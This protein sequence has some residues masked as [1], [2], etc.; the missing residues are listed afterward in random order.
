MQLNSLLCNNVGVTVSLRR[1]MILCTRVFESA[2]PLAEAQ[3]FCN[4]GVMAATTHF[5]LLWPEV[6]VEAGSAQA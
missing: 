6:D 2:K 4:M 5:N 1:V 3:L